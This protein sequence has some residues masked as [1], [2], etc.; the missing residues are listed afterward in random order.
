MD[1]VCSEEEIRGWLA[2]KLESFAIYVPSDYGFKRARSR[3]DIVLNFSLPTMPIKSIF[4]PHTDIMMKFERKFGRT[5]VVES[6]PEE[7]RKIVLTKACDAYSIRILD[8]VF[9]SEPV[10]PY[11][12]RRRK[13]TIFVTIACTK[14]CYAGFCEKLGVQPEGDVIITPLNNYYHVEVRNKEL[15]PDFES[16]RRADEKD[17]ERAMKNRIAPNPA[18]NIDWL[19]DAF[20]DE[21]WEEFSR[22][23]ISCGICTYLCPTCHC[24]DITDDGSVRIR[25]WDSCQFPYFT[26][27]TSGHNP[28]P[29][30]KHR[31]RN[32]IYHKFSYFQQRYG[33]IA[34]VGCGRCVR[35]CPSQI[36]IREL[37]LRRE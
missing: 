12:E 11:Y 6:L 33:F 30:R 19:K 36:D 20:E 21:I 7:E 16:F 32:R 15:L 8:A 24:F 5:I 31:L 4:F 14:P 25:T 35:F 10:D 29:E 23:C 1:F 26:M 13:N 3:E 37:V 27:H 22:F 9:L 28:R 2:S 34:C 17:R 18:L